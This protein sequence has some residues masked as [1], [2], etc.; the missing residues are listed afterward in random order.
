MAPRHQLNHFHFARGE[1][2]GVVVLRTATRRQGI[3]GKR[4]VEVAAAR[5]HFTNR[6]SKIGGGS[7]F[8]N[9]ARS[10]RRQKRADVCVIAVS[11]KRQ[12]LYVGASGSQSLGSLRSIEAGHRHI[13]NGYI[14]QQFARN[15]P[16]AFALVRF[17]YHFHVWLG[18]DEHHQSLSHQNVVIGHQN[19]QSSWRFPI[20]A[21][22][23]VDV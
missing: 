12:N 6:V 19:T 18:I 1:R 20:G 16:R 4:F 2:N 7:A 14:G 21:I 23:I 8:E 22:E 15:P 10:S 5:R 9:V 17:A 13:Q 3:D 11:R